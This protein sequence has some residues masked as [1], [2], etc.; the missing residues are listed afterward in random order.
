VIL[1][2]L[3]GTVTWFGCRLDIKAD[4]LIMHDG[5]SLDMSQGKAAAG[6]SCQSCVGTESEPCRKYDVVLLSC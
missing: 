3:L 4:V 2:C 5:A 1:L 6:K